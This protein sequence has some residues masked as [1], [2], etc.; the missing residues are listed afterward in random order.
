MVGVRK[1]VL[2]DKNNYNVFDS[3]LKVGQ[4]NYT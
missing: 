3:W 4:L 2:L 1:L